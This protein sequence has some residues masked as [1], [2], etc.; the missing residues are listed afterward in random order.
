[1]S[2]VTTT[3]RGLVLAAVGAGGALGA[4][5]AARAQDATTHRVEMTDE[6][7]FDPD[8][9]TVA[10]GD[11]VV[12]ETVG[13]IGHSVTA[14]E[15]E[16]PDDAAYFA[17]DGLEDESSARS[18]YPDEGDVAEGETYEHTFEVEGTYDYFCIPHESVGMLGTI[19]VG[20]DAGGGGG[21]ATEASGEAGGASGVE[22]PPSAQVLGVATTVAMVAVLGL[23]YV[24]LR[25][26]GYD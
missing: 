14:Y 16:I 11:T 18:A 19:T 23:A 20:A 2:Q 1:M 5:A 6:L 10:P 24:M 21:D 12:W 22:V 15:D 9:L 25:Y 17:S 4:T 26:G 3:R 13:S 8:A 7:V